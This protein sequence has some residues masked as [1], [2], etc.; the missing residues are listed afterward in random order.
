MELVTKNSCTIVA[1]CR[2]PGWWGELGVLREK[3]Q[4]TELACSIN[5]HI[6]KTDIRPRHDALVRS[7]E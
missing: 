2:Y 7:H 1:S 5:R 3:L 6:G 4:Q